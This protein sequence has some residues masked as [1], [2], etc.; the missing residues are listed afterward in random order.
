MKT[1]LY[2]LPAVAIGFVTYLILL[3]TGTVNFPEE[4]TMFSERRMYTKI[5]NISIKTP[6]GQ[7]DFV[8]AVYL[9]KK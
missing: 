4:K 8:Q 5:H 9:T 6:S 3:F 7:N 1:L 2:L